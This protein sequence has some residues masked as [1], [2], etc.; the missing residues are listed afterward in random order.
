M[1][2]ETLLAIGGTLIGVLSVFGIYHIA[3]QQGVFK[4]NKIYLNIINPDFQDKIIYPPKSDLVIYEIPQKKTKSSFLIFLP[5]YIENRSK[6]AIR[7]VRIVVAHEEILNASWARSLFPSDKKHTGID[8]EYTLRH[9]LNTDYL[10]DSLRIGQ[11]TMLTHL[12]AFEDNYFNKCSE[13]QEQLQK[14]IYK[15]TGFKLYLSEVIIMISAENI[16]EIKF[17]TTLLITEFEEELDVTKLR[18][19]QFQQAKSLADEFFANKISDR[20]TLNANYYIKRFF[21]Q[22]IDKGISKR[23]F[24]NMPDF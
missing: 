14:T 15:N 24:I 23:V 13:D 10:I 22:L 17:N 16:K 21:S 5:I 19:K 12:V 18:N 4:R 2:V 3:F 9:Y 6:E 11:R 7:N 20:I 8:R 1:T